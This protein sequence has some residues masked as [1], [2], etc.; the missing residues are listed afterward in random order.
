[1]T[2]RFVVVAD[3]LRPRVH[4]GRIADLL[5]RL[6]F[7]ARAWTQGGDVFLAESVFYGPRRTAVALTAH[8]AEHNLHPFDHHQHLCG[9][10]VPV[11]GT[12]H[13]HADSIAWAES[14][15]P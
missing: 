15:I 7:R 9:K 6:G 12:R 13:L 4:G 5:G 2:L 1:M 10:S 11:V 14:V 8:E 3:R